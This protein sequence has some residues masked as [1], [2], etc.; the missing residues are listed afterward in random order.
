[1]RSL[2]NLANANGSIQSL[3]NSVEVI[4][5]LIYLA[6]HAETHTDEQH[7]YLDWAARIIGELQHH[8]K[9]RE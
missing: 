7:Q 1:M 8:P 6:R 5:N 4:A 9:A 2:E 3:Q